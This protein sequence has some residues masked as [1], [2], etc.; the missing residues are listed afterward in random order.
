MLMGEIR[1]V[2]PLAKKYR[3]K[4]EDHHYTKENDGYYR[5]SRVYQIV[6]DKDGREIQKNL[7]L[8]NHSKVMFDPNQIPKE[9]LRI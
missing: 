6:S 3:L 1:S 8:E 7:I 5:N 2:A 4:E 9:E